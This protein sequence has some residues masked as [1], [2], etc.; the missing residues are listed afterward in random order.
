MFTYRSKAIAHSEETLSSPEAPLSYSVA[1]LSHSVAALSRSVAA[2]SHSVAPL[3]HS[4]AVFKS[5][6][7][8]ISI[9]Y[10]LIIILI[11][12]Y[13][14]NIEIG[15]TVYFCKRMIRIFLVCSLTLYLSSMRRPTSHTISFLD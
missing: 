10:I 11:N 12:N 4:G 2:L 8:Y 13:G 7:C 3:S 14:T 6:K 5:S 1:T 9:N 15:L